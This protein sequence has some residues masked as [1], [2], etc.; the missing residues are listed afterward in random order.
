VRAVSERERWESP[1]SPARAPSTA[2]SARSVA[3]KAAGGF[4]FDLGARLD[5]W[6]KTRTS[7]DAQRD[8]AWITT[9]YVT[10]RLGVLLVAYLNGTF[11]HHAI[12]GE[13]AHWDGVWYRA[14]A[15]HGYPHHVTGRQT[16]LGFF[17]LF[18]VTIWILT[19]VVEIATTHA[20]LWASTV[21]GLLISGVGGWIAS[22]FVYRL[23]DGWWG[24]QT[25]RRAVVL[26]IVFP[27]AV[28]FSMDYSEGLLLPLAAGCLWALQQR[29]WW[30]AGLLAAF[31]T[32]VQPAGLVITLMCMTA[33]A[34]E[35]RRG[36]WRSRGFRAAVGTTAFSGLGALAFMGFL[37]A[38]TGTPFATYITQ[39]RGWDEKTDPLALVHLTTR[40]ANELAPAH[41]NHPVI[42]PNLIVGLLGVPV[43]VVMLVLAW[44]SRKEMSHPALIW[45]AAIAFLA[46]TSEY[47]PPNPRLL[48]T[49]FPGLMAIARWCTGRRYA[50][51]IAVNAFLLLLLGAM[52]FTAHILR[53]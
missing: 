33:A 48:L 16:N 45:T 25:A 34:D 44:R 46:V 42:D 36:G 26:F 17:P 21:A 30:L 7:S 23:A 27:G 22:L 13:L 28:V 11:G 15:N 40:L 53:P 9:I 31:G 37:W 6:L 51:V 41:F 32:A 19:P 29:R 38:W 43:L 14:I 8:L 52:T 4:G 1:G 2:R 49:A 10:T 39:H 18:P 35:L 50:V 47:V 5:R 3:G 20:R 12:L 24:R